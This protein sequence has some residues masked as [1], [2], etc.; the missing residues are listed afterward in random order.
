MKRL[1]QQLAI[2]ALALLLL[3]AAGVYALSLLFTDLCGNTVVAEAVSPDQRLKAV[4]FQRDC[5]AAT[6]FSTQVSVIGAQDALPNASGSV[7]SA[8]SNR[9][10]VPASAAGGPVVQ[11][12]WV[13]G[14]ALVITHHAGAR[15]F[16]QKDSVSG[17]A[18]AYEQVPDR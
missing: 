10:A 2:A 18:V 13:S 14:S 4:V 5:G 1:P 3:I 9:G 12:R 15:V 6:G 16:T 11:V 8:D 17:V 7:F